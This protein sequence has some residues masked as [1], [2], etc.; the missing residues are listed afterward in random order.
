MNRNFQTINAL[1]SPET[2][3]QENFDSINYTSVYGK[4]HEVTNGLAWGYWGGRWG[5]FGISDGT[6]ALANNDENYMIVN[7]A[8]GVATMESGIGSPAVPVNWNDTTNYG[9][10]YHITVEN[11]VVTNVEDYRAGP[12]GVHGAGTAGGSAGTEITGLTFT[13]DTGSTA[14]SD[15]G[16]G[17]FKW[18]N[19]TQGSA[20][21]L[22]FDNLTADGVSLATLWAS[23]GPSG[24]IYLQQADD[25]S[26]WQE[27]KWTAAPVDGTGYRKFTVVLQAS[28]G[29]I[30]DNKTVYVDF[31]SAGTP[32]TPGSD[33]FGYLNIPQNS[34]STA[35]TTV[36]GDAGK[37]ILHPVADN[38]ARTFT[39]DSNAN[40]AYPIGTAITFVNEMNTVTIAITSDTLTFAGAG[41]TGSRTLAAAGIATALKVGTTKWLISGTG[42]T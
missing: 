3:I 1:A 14:D 13:S 4:R 22:Y 35:Y 37:H 32:S 39:I 12:G 25:R 8:T 27:W 42:L 23:M 31:E 26:K 36:L 15:P 2:Q 34:Q 16:N 19:A 6:L 41:T 40:V 20:T 30:V 38:N 28:G 33:N 29:S 5:G 11:G 21:V 18:N 7:R 9:R 17:L 24:F 10:V